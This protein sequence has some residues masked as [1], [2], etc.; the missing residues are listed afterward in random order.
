MT[1][2]NRD[3][4]I[5]EV[6][7]D[8]FV[9]IAKLRRDPA[10]VLAAAQEREIVLFHENKPTPYIVPPHLWPRAQRLLKGPPKAGPAQRQLKQL[11]TA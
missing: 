1:R 9:P 2:R 8:M 10:R 6:H 11:G 4:V 5:H 7:A 3:K